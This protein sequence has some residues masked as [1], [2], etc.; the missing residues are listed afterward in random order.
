MK[1]FD[2]S[3]VMQHLVF[4]LMVLLLGISYIT[5]RT[6]SF[7]PIHPIFGYVLIAGLIY[8]ITSDIICIFRKGKDNSGNLIYKVSLNDGK[9][10]ELTKTYWDWWSDG[11]TYNFFHN[12]KNR[13]IIP[14]RNILMIE[15]HKEAK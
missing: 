13:I 15:T 2:F 5:Q 3:Y 11:F 10:L 1:R 6:I 8:F 14:K 7:H 4:L 9:I 12:G